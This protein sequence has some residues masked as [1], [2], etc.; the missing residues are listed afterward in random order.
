MC[1][2]TDEK[3][4]KA[5]AEIPDKDCLGIVLLCGFAGEDLRGNNRWCLESLLVFC[6]KEGPWLQPWMCP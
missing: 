4:V 3:C 1:R 2:G 6:H 5:M